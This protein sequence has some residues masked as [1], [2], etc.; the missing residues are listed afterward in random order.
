MRA[1]DGRESP[2]PQGPPIS[3]PDLDRVSRETSSSECRDG[4]APSRRTQEERWAGCPLVRRA[5]GTVH[6]P[7]ARRVGEDPQP[8]SGYL[9]HRKSRPRADDAV[10]I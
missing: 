10:Q 8:L 5:P 7:V 1:A 3:L 4:E 6:G 2:A 9:Q